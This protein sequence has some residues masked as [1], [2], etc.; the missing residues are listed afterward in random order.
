M[1]FNLSVIRDRQDRVVD[2]FPD[3]QLRSVITGGVS[4]MDSRDMSNWAVH[5]GLEEGTW[6]INLINNPDRSRYIQQYVQCV[7]ALER[8]TEWR[9]KVDGPNNPY[10][11]VWV[12]LIDKLRQTILKNPECPISPEDTA[13]I[14]VAYQRYKSVPYGIDDR[15][16]KH[17]QF[18]KDFEEIFAGDEFANLREA[19]RQP[20]TRQ[21]TVKHCGLL[22]LEIQDPEERTRFIHLYYE[23]LIAHANH[24]FAKKL[25]DYFLKH[26]GDEYAKTFIGKTP[27]EVH[28]LVTRCDACFRA[29]AQ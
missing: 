27:K 21:V 18:D 3:P 23:A 19:I 20:I 5:R 29:V 10:A 4:A 2:F 15:R 24:P 26:I 12:R 17:E 28:E 6:S 22:L 25:A 13:C 9:W 8:Q 1:T 11:P 7:T 16:Q 14:E